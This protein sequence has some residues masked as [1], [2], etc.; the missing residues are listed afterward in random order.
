MRT[1]IR[2]LIVTQYFAP[3]LGAVPQRLGHYAGALARAGHQVTVLT[4]LPSYPWGR[5]LPQYR[6][7]PLAIERQGDVKVIRTPTR[8]LG[9]EPGFQDRLL[10]YGLFVLSAAP[11]VAALARRAD[12]ALVESPPLSTAL[13]ALAL[14]RLGTPYVLSVSDLWPKSA[15]EVGAVRDPRIV[16]AAERLEAAAYRRA[17]RVVGLTEGICDHVRAVVPHEKV[18]FL[19]NGV[20]PQMFAAFRPGASTNGSYSVVY[21]GTVGLA[22]GLEVL[23]PAA[24]ELRAEEVHFTVVGDGAAR[25]G[26]ARL[27]QAR[28]V[29]NL[30]LLG[31]RPRSEVLGLLQRADA[32]LVSL[33][34]TPVLHGAVP[35]K[36]YE[37]MA[38]AR[39]VVLVAEGEAAR[40]VE[41]VGC[42]AVVPPGRPERLA[43]AVR[44]IRRS[45]Q[46]DSMGRRGQEFVFAH[47][48]VNDHARRLEALLVET[49][50]EHAQRDAAG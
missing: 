8:A 29:D 35:S 45:G 46:A 32:A 30:H 15:V 4:T 33:R 20:D 34:D 38:S 16:G 7:R 13:L 1:R 40:L 9:Q 11:A 25:E 10:T 27:K 47:R 42:G 31:P 41:E 43:A 18:A 44:S 5:T 2:I 36:L 22:Q 39:P 19:P 26:I 48:D 23:V 24:E 14:R 12:V 3:E 21:A 50:H 49:V 37:A 17:S 28:G 6:M